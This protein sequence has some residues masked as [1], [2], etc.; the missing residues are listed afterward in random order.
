[1]HFMNILYFSSLTLHMQWNANVRDIKCSHFYNLFM[2]NLRVFAVVKQ[3]LR[4][5]VHME[6]LDYH[7]LDFHKI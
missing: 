6:Q 7:Q 5:S 2:Y 1:M 4:L 3:P